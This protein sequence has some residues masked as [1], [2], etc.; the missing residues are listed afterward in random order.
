MNHPQP[1][2]TEAFPCGACGEPCDSLQPCTWDSDLMVGPC[3][4]IHS[5]ELPENRPLCEELYRLVCRAATVQ[6][7]SEAFEAHAHSGCSI[8]CPRKEAAKAE[9]E[10]KQERR[11]A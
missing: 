4:Q 8:C 7:V 9:V 2:Y 11:A 5:D 3:C 6:A 10:L 1:F